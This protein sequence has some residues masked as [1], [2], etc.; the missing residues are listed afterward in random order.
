MIGLHLFGKIL[1]KPFV[2]LYLVMP[3]AK[4][5]LPGDLNGGLSIGT[6]IEPGFR[7]PVDASLIGIDADEPRY[8]ETL[9]VY[10][11]IFEWVYDALGGTGFFFKFFF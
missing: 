7:P 3:E 11:Q 9:Y 8:V 1:F 5:V 2:F 4:G 6:V 10:V